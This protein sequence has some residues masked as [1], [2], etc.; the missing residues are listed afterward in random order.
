M[1]CGGD[2]GGVEENLSLAAIFEGELIS[3]VIIM[4]WGG[5]VNSNAGLQY[6][7]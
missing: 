5:F 2:G 4:C 6:S 7:Y 1:E 3:L